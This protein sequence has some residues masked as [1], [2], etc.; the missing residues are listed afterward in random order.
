MRDLSLSASRY[1]E[2]P[3]ERA[4][5]RRGPAPDPEFHDEPFR[6][7]KKKRSV[8]A[9]VFAPHRVGVMLLL[10][11]GGLAFVGVPMNALFLQDGHHPAPLFSSRK[12]APR[13]VEESDAPTP[14]ARP[15]QMEAAVETD[16]AAKPEPAPA[17]PAAKP[18]KA[19]AAA[20]K[21]VILKTEASPAA[22]IEKKREPVSHDQI[23]AVLGGPEAAKTTASKPARAQTQSKPQAQPLPKP[24]A[25]T[26][27]KAEAQTLA[28]SEGVAFAQR[29][30]QRLGYVVKA[31]GVMSDGTRRAI[32]KFERDNGLP[33][34]GELTA[35]VAKL[36]ASRAATPH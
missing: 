4:P 5:R 17:L 32:E 23:A 27:P 9:R 16:L 22:K 14:R 28:P 7:P 35:K 24:E 21:A 12:L 29:A 2:F 33:P 11:I 13:Y 36:L 3:E 26:Q 31:D 15:A 18:T 8:L 10:G 20:L 1:D 19:D 34:K 30:L 6:L 25:Q